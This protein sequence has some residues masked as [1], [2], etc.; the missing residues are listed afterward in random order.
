VT[1]VLRALAAF[2]ALVA[3]FARLSDTWS[4]PRGFRRCR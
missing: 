3:L 1:G 4:R 2:D